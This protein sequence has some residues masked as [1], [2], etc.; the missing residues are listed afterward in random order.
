MGLKISRTTVKKPGQNS[1]SFKRY[2][3]KTENM[4]RPPCIPESILFCIFWASCVS[5]E[6]PVYLWRVLQEKGA[7]RNCHRTLPR[8]TGRPKDTQDARK[9]QNRTPQRYKGALTYFQFF[10]DIFLRKTSFNLVFSQ[11]FLKFV[12]P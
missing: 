7:L 6:H 12:A 4:L 3:G 8:Y 10:S 9:I 1:F 5:L 2:Q 11:L